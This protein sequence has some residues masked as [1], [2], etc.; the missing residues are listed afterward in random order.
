[1]DSADKVKRLTDVEGQEGNEWL[2][3][4]DEDNVRMRRVRSE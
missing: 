4:E 3:S 2:G 1:M